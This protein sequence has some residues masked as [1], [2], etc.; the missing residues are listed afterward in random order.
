MRALD[1]RCS[2][3]HVREFIQ[4]SLVSKDDRAPLDDAES[5]F[6]SG[7]LDS[8]AVTRLVVFLEQTFGVDFGANPFDLDSLDSV[9]LIC[10]Y[11]AA[12][13]R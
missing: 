7:R 12:N 2:Q 6:L 3:A 5:L 13:G 9:A 10:E 11:A 1:A 4:K 8:L